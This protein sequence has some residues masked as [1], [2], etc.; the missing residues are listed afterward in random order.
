MDMNTD[1]AE[2]QKKLFQLFMA[3]KA[4]C[5]WEMQG[6][7]AI[8][9]AL[10]AEVIP[11]LWKEIQQNI[12]DAGGLASWEAL[13]PNERESREIAAYQRVCVNLGEDRLEALT[14]EERRYASLFIWG[15][16]CMH[17]EMNSVKGGNTRMMV[18]WSENDL[19]GPMKLYNRDNSAAAALGGEAARERASEVSQAGGVKLT[20]LAG[21]VFANK[22]KKKGQQDTLQVHLQS[23]VGYMVCFPGTSSTRY[24][25]HGDAAIELIVRLDFYR[26]FLEIV[27]DL[28]EKRNFTNIEQN[29]YLGLHDNPT[30]TELC[31]LILYALSVTHP[32]MRQV[33][34]PNATETNLLDMGPVHDKV[35]A[36]CRAIIDNPDLLL[37]SE[38]SYTTGSMDGVIWEQPDAFYAVHALASGLPHLRGAMI[39]FFEGAL[40]TWLRFTSEYQPDGLIAS[41]SAAERLRAY[42]LPT[43][44]DNE[45]G[46]GEKRVT[47]RHAPNMTLESHNA[48][49]T[50]RKNNT[51]A[52]IRK[53]LTLTDWKYLRRKACEIDS[54][55]M[56]KKRREIQAAAQQDTVEKKRK[57][58]AERKAAHS[59]KCAKIDAVVAR[60]DV[61]SIQDAP[62]TNADLDLQLEWHRRQDTLVPKKTDV[63]LKVDKIKALVE[64]VERH[65]SGNQVAVVPI[66]DS[67]I[68]VDVPSDLDEEEDDFE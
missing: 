63:K 68:Q 33:R 52:F 21:A 7:E 32:Y 61:Q 22:D 4:S 1:H 23:T 47:T 3:W 40:D 53:T 67:V 13:P 64:A 31:V 26:Q 41:A 65:N 15:G 45:G 37:S 36:H 28:K 66:D 62:G 59:A 6:Q 56:A 34:G 9:S 24:G 46:L 42:M 60:L 49:A 8:L 44:D 51:S 58:T 30:I 57:A 16:C 17:K 5:E 2:N 35:I 54:S 18:W 14:P 12:A 43:N 29:I 38:A 10:L 39:A 19:V 48:R 55:G 25:S 50:Y 20:S 11:L 27:R